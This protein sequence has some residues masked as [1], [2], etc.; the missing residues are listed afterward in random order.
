MRALALRKKSGKKTTR[1]A[2]G[3]AIYTQPAT[4]RGTA[5][6]PG[7]DARPKRALDAPAPAAAHDFS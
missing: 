5:Q 7:A 6:Q 4:R 1:D 3:I 2:T